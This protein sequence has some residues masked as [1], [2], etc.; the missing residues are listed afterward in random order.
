MKPIVHISLLRTSTAFQIFRPILVIIVIIISGCAGLQPSSRETVDALYKPLQIEDEMVERNAP[1]FL[2]E[3]YQTSHNRIGKP[4]ARYDTQGN[5]EVYIN[6]DKP[7]IYTLVRE[8]KTEK[9]VYTNLIYRVHFSKVPFS[10]IP[11]HITAGK[12]VGIFVI[13]TMDLE[14]RPV[15]VTTLGTCG[16]YLAIVP[17]TWLPEDSLPSGWEESPIDVYGETL[18]SRLD[19]NEFEKPR[20]LVRIR[21]HV[22]RIMDLDIIEKDDLSQFGNL[23]MI[24]A[25]LFPIDELKEIPIDGESTSFYYEDGPYQG[26]VKGA[27]KPWE[28]LFMGL[29]SLD[30]L[31]GTDKIYGDSQNMR[32]PFYTSLKPWNRNSSD[33]WNF[34]K[35]LEF[36]G[37][38]L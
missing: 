34:S 17:T 21:S 35:F 11:F 24:T 33:M 18:P 30:S 16:C 27:F 6:P 32:T 13:I 22:H 14:D 25:P 1:L 12:N 5:E 29:I 36:W 10:I 8:F 7:A 15:L 28:T 31:V 4:L 2:V 38:R 19:M 3:D 23:R 9:A 20:I 26:L 37:W